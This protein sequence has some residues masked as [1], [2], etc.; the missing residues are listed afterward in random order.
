[1]SFSLKKNVKIF[2][3]ATCVA[4]QAKFKIIMNLEGL[5]FPYKAYLTEITCVKN[6]GAQGKYLIMIMGH[7]SLLPQ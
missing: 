3:I 7:F 2:C 6:T 5:V 4:E 1:M